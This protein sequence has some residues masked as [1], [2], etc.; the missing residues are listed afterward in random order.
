MIRASLLMLLLLA[1]S[2]A[3]VAHAQGLPS[4]DPLTL[5]ITPSYPRP[6]QTV[7]IAPQS[8]LVDLSASTVKM[9]VNGAQVYQGSGTQPTSVRAGGLGERTTIVVT[10]TDPYGKTYT[11]TQV[12]RPAEVSLV[13]EPASTAPALYKGG[14]LV[15]SEGRVRLVALA[16]WGK[17]YTAAATA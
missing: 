9:S 16:E 2:I 12:I 17:A 13:M 6:Y 14:S 4:D 11:K 8:N 10:V 3:P 1:G 5:S 15:A 7:T